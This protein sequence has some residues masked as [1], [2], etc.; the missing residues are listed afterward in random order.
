MDEP[1]DGRPWAN[2]THRNGFLAQ[3][4]LPAGI[5]CAGAVCG[6]GIDGTGLRTGVVGVEV[7]VGGGAV[8]PQTFGVVAGE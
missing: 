8:L 6:A 7:T 5:F 1:T 3:K 2:A 4:G